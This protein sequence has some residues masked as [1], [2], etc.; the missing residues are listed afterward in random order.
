MRKSLSV[1]IVIPVNAIVPTV[2]A[3][4]PAGRH[5]V[6][7]LKSINKAAPDALIMPLVKNDFAYKKPNRL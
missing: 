2:V 4:W 3:K 5:L 6:A 1:I 7:P